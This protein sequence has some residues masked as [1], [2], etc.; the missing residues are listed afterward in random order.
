MD[1]FDVGSELESQISC[2]AS[3]QNIDVN[4]KGEGVSDWTALMLAVRK[5]HTSIVKLLL[6]EPNIDVN[7]KDHKDRCAL[8]LAVWS[9]FTRDPNHPNDPYPYPNPV[10]I[11]ALKLLL[12]FPKLDVTSHQWGRSAVYEAVWQNNIE[13][14]NLL[15]NHPNLTAL[16]INQKEPDEGNTPVMLAA[17]WNRLEHLSVLAADL[18]VDLDTTDKNGKSLEEW[19]GNRPE[20]RR[21]VDEA[22]QIRRGLIRDQQRNVSKVLLDGL[23]DSDSTF[24]KLLGVR[25]EVLGE[26]IWQKL[27]ENWQIY[28]EQHLPPSVDLP[29]RKIKCTVL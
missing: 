16:T 17:R 1:S 15:L 19:T 25:K 7:Q 5:N 9:E 2:R 24:S 10:A 23:Y 3:S 14:L 20:F 29:L 26:I 6:K 21:V 8:Q 13:T 28:P 12:N 22:K 18:R 11:E 27:I 4:T